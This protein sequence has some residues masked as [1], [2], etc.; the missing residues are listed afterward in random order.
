[1]EELTLLRSRT[2][3]RCGDFAELDA[4]CAASRYMIAKARSH[5]YDSKLGR[6]EGIIMM[7][8][9]W[10][11][12]FN[13]QCE[14]AFR[15]YEKCLGGK[16]NVMMTWGESPMAKDVPADWAM[17]ITH[18]SL[19]IGNQELTGGD[20]PS[21]QFEKPQGF[22]VILNMTDIAEADRVFKQ[23][24]ADGTIRIPF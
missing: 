21:S 13:G 9:G 12:A 1:M 5:T 19:I 20:L 22:S 2:R 14:E 10:N 23:L 15:F 17:K 18:A 7:T 16:I 11:L 3:R 4:R 6:Q 8:L 24:S